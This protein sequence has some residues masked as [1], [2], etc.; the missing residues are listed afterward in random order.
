MGL[1]EEPTEIFWKTDFPERVFDRERRLQ[2]YQNHRYT[3]AISKKEI[4]PLQSRN[5]SKVPY[6]YEKGYI[7]FEY[8]IWIN[9][10]ILNSL[11]IPVLFSGDYD[12]KYLYLSLKIHN[13]YPDMAVCYHILRSP[14]Y[15]AEA[16]E[17][18][19]TYLIKGQGT[20]LIEADIETAIYT[21]TTSNGFLVI[22]SRI[23][24]EPDLAFIQ[25]EDVEYLFYFDLKFPSNQKALFAP[26]IGGWGSYDYLLKMNLKP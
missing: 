18:K 15:S 9:A 20:N 16:Y 21:N 26:Q 6:D 25:D 2:E 3:M 17:R 1:S 13:S 11:E 12:D 4:T 19:F 22:T 5:I 8:S 24:K 14:S 7:P 10:P 23:P